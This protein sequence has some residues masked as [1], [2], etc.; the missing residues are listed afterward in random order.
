M[1]QCCS[2]EPD[3]V[4][5]HRSAALWAAD[6]LSLAA[7]PTFAIMALLSSV[8]GDGSSITA[9]MATHASPMTGMF[10]MYLLMSAFHAAAWLKLLRAARRSVRGP[11][12]E[13][14][15]HRDELTHMIRSVVHCNQEGAQIGL[16]ITP[17][18]LRG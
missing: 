9:G 13:Q 4:A 16:S 8:A 14:L 2:G 10:I 18:N 11:R 6:A 15:A 12:T 5:T 17:R 3:S 1:S 7:S